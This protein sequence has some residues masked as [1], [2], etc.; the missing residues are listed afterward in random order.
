MPQ[1]VVVARL[2]AVY[3]Q[4]LLSVARRQRWLTASGSLLPKCGAGV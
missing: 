4:D 1:F 3:G 2:I